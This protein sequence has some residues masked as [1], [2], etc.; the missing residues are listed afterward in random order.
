VLFRRTLDNDRSLDD[1]IRER[2]EHN[3]KYN[4][5]TIFDNLDIFQN[6]G[7]TNN[8]VHGSKD[9]FNAKKLLGTPVEVSEDDES[10]D[11]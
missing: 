6:I 5:D 10:S 3:L 8:K 7:E 11:K 9:K 4:D 2:I 1:S